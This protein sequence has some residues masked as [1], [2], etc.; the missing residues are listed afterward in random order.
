MIVLIPLDDDGEDGAPIRF[1]QSKIH[2][3]HGP[4]NDLILDEEDQATSYEHAMITVVDGRAVVVCELTAKPTYIDGADVSYAPEAERQLHPGEVISFGKGRSIFRVQ[5]IGESVGSGE[6]QKVRMHLRA[7]KDKRG[8]A[9]VIK[10][11]APGQST[12]DESDERPIYPIAFL[13]FKGD[14]MVR[15]ELFNQ[16]LIRIG[17]MKSSH[18]QLDDESVSR[19]H[20]VVEVTQDKEVL[21]MDLDS[22]SGTAVNGARVKK[23]VLKPG[24]QVDFGKARVIIS[25]GKA[26]ASTAAPT[27]VQAAPEKRERRRRSSPPPT[28]YAEPI[29]PSS[30][31]VLSPGIGEAPESARLVVRRGGVEQDEFGL[32]KPCTTIGRLAENDSQLDDGAVSGKHAMVVAEAGVYLVVDQ[33]ST[34]GTYV[35]GERC[36]GESLKDG[37]VIQIGRYELVFV[38]PRPSR[39]RNAPGTEV[40]SPEAARA[41]FAKLRGRRGKDR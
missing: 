5:E 36:A 33:R 2:V 41:M 24:D 9:P 21:L 18:L 6:P 17:R 19:T 40:L 30:T 39:A 8:S 4:D 27:P 34:N 3:G 10:I 16:P 28:P 14:Q 20:A 37:D 7:I 23:A 31:Q 25:Y 26:P 15:E 12:P 13:V 32:T 22:S 11:P 29:G 1:D 38:A 35:N